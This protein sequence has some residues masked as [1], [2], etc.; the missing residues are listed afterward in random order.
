[1]EEDTSRNSGI[2]EVEYDKD[3]DK[4]T[5]V[6]GP[7]YLLQIEKVDE[8]LKFR[9]GATHH[10]FEAKASGIDKSNL[11]EVIN[12]VREEYPDKKIDEFNR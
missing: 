4:L 6:F 3:S 11:E 8:D 1:M 12:L 10:G 9:L 7:H 5:V 2:R